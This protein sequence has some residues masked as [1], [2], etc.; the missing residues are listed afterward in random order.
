MLTQ[1]VN[2]FKLFRDCL[3]SSFSFRADA[4]MELID[5]LSGN[6]EADS[7]VQLS[8]SPIFRRRYG[9]VRD[10]IHNFSSDPQQNIRIEKC[11][12]NYCSP[13]TKTQPFRLMVIDCTAAPR[14]YSKTLTDR[15]IIY[16]PNVIPGNKPITVGHQYS[17]MGFLPEQTLEHENIPWMLP[18]STRRVGTN[19]NEIQI[20]IEQMDSVVNNFGEDLTVILGDTTYSNPRFIEKT[21]KHNNAILI[22]RLQGNRIINRQ[23]IPKKLSRT[24]RRGRGHELWYGDAFHFK[25]QSTWGTADETRTIVFK[26]RKN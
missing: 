17:I 15:G 22:A 5:A 10:A 9:S 14:K 3:F 19:T 11:L 12:M 24:N 20:G 8:L 25:D 1:S 7:V 13:I 21:Q 23:A 26:A 2:K 16:A 18:I 6:T 4:T